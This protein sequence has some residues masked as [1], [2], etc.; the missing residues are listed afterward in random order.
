MLEVTI[1]EYVS[2]WW[3]DCSL[4]SHQNYSKAYFTIHAQEIYVHDFA[5][6]YQIE[7]CLELHLQM[8]CVP[9]HVQLTHQHQS[10]LS[11][12]STVIKLQN[13]QGK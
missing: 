13:K 6:P 9:Q 12:K 1:H 4:R 2:P 11:P 5:L 8:Q 10:T 3:C 7:I